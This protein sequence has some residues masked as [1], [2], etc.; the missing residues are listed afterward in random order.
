MPPTPSGRPLHTSGLVVL[1]IPITL[2]DGS[3]S[4]RRDSWRIVVRHWLEGNPAHGLFKPLKDWTKAELTGPNKPFA[5]KRHGRMV[6]ATEFTTQYHSDEASFLS[7]YPEANEGLSKL[8][9]AVNA[10]RVSRGDRIPRQ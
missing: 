6:I 2:S 8:L 10:A 9:A 1:D 4:H 5:M 7:A 3:T